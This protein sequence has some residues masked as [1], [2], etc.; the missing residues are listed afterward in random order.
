MDSAVISVSETVDFQKIFI[1]YWK[2]VTGQWLSPCP[3][4]VSKNTPEN[5]KCGINL[6]RI[7]KISSETMIYD[8]VSFQEKRVKK[9]DELL[10]IEAFAVNRD[11][12][13]WSL[14][15]KPNEW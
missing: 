14:K 1:A 5:V 2:L 7:V 13:L 4:F 3:V 11:I 12:C 9:N 6:N 8:F 10:L 15:N